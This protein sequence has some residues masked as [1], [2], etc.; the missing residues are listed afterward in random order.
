RLYIGNNQLMGEIPDLSNLTKLWRLYLGKNQLTGSI[1]ELP[2]SLQELSL[3]DNQLEGAI[4]NLPANLQQLYISG[5]QLCQDP[6]ANYAGRTEVEAFPICGTQPPEPVIAEPI[7]EDNRVNLDASGSSDLDP[8]GEITNYRWVTSDGQ[9]ATGVNPT[10]TFPADG[11][12]TITLIV[13]DNTGKTSELEK[14]VTTGYPTPTGPF[15]LTIAKRGTGEG[16][17]QSTDMAIDCDGACQRTR[18]DYAKDTEVTLEATPSDGSMLTGWTGACRGTENSTTVTMSR[19][20]GCTATFELDPT[21]VVLHRVRISKIGDGK[22][23]ITIKQGS[24]VIMTCTTAACEAK[25][26]AP[27]TE[28]TLRARARNNAIFVGWGEDCSGTDLN[29]S[30]TINKATKC[31]ADF[32]LPPPLPTEH[33]LTVTNIMETTAR[34]YVTGNGIE[35]GD[36]CVE[37]YL[38]DKKVRLTANPMPHSYFKKWTNDCSGTRTSATVIMDS[39]KTCT[40]IFG[41]D[42]DDAAE[43]MANE[44]KDVGKLVNPEGEPQELNDV[45]PPTYNDTCY[46]EAFRLAENA[47]QVV[48]EQYIISKTWP[49]HFKKI[50]SWF[51]PSPDYFCTKKVR[52]MSGAENLG[53]DIVEGNYIQVDVE[54]KNSE[55]ELEMVSILVYYDSEPTIT[56]APTRA[57]CCRRKICHHRRR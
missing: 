45:F 39:D 44:F 36:D 14:V 19:R 32:T 38:A 52:I 20:R 35:C 34:G 7:I 26:Y 2:T 29:L 51:E 43:L 12:Y 33:R 10:I 24:N 56:P 55:Q 11:E 18:S 57:R 8:N 41:S 28:L 5:N 3:T 15:T 47:M 42:S 25:Y 9:I 40:A 37:N 1:P 21:E 49:T 30:I 31:T 54:L 53:G 50:Q 17:I 48:E 4:P 13:T 22:G 46:Q 23:T 6:E 16:T 27:G